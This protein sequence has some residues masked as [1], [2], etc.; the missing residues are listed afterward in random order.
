MNTDNNEFD[1]SIQELEAKLSQWKVAPPAID[2]KIVFYQAG[3][4]AASTQ[5]QNRVWNQRW[6]TAASLLIAI[7]FS[8]ILSYRAGQS[9]VIGNDNQIATNAAPI[10]SPATQEQNAA[11]NIDQF[12]NIDQVAS[13]ADTPVAGDNWMMVAFGDWLQD[14]LPTR[15]A[16]DNELLAAADANRLASLQ[17]L[18]QPVANDSNQEPDRL[19]E[20]LDAPEFAPLRKQSEVRSLLWNRL[21]PTL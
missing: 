1:P 18:Q 11:P 21:L 12:E 9:S 14:K 7:S 3:F 17:A 6:L 4:A 16:R 19:E 8:S 10:Q 15:N 2:P 13:P 5:N 20:F